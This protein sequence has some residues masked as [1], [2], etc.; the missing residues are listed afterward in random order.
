MPSRV[1]LALTVTGLF[2]VPVFLLLAQ[3]APAPAKSAPPAKVVTTVTVTPLDQKP[4]YSKEGVVFQQV[5]NNWTYNADGTGTRILEVVARVQSDAAVQSFGVL[6]FNYAAGDEQVTIDYLR[7]R[8]PDGTVVDTPPTDAE[9][10][11]TEVTREAPFYSDLKQLQIPVKSLS[12]G[13]QL[14]YR[15]RF[16]LIHPLAAGQ[17]WGSESW[18][19]SNVVLNETVELSI[20]DGKYVLVLS[21]KFPPKITDQNGRRIYAWQSSQLQPTGGDT[22]N[23]TATPDPD[24]LPDLSWTSWRNWQEIGDWYA[25]LAKD[26]VAVTPEIQS[27]VQELIQGK[28]SDDAKIEAIYDYVSLQVR[29]IGVAFGIGRYQPHAAETV[30]EN[31]YG[32]CK[33]KDTLLQTM[34]KAA[35]YDAWPALIGSSRKLHPELPSPE[36]FDHV[37]TVVQRGDSVIWLDSTPEVAPYRLL[38]FALRDK[39]ALVIPT[40]GEPKLMRTPA[41]GPFPF[42]TE[43]SAIASL[44]S[45]GTLTGHISFTVR[46]DTEVLFRA[47]YRATPRAQW[48]QLAQNM[49]QAMGFAGT[50][51][52][53]DVSRPDRTDDPFS[54][55]WKY[56]RKEYADWSD[57]RILPLMTGL[58]LPAPGDS[59]SVIELQA[60]QI[61]SFHSEITLP[62]QY[63]AVLPKSVHY[64]SAFATYDSTYKLVGGK[65]ISDRKFQVLEEQVPL[66]QWDKYKQ[67]SD[68]VNNDVNQFVQL[69]AAG[70]PMPDTSPSNPD[71]V[72]LIQAAWA[73][74][75]NHNPS[76]ARNDLQSAEQLNPRERGLWA[77]FGVL[78]A[79]DNRMD[80]AVADLQK[81]IQYHPDSAR[82][83]EYLASLQVRMQK[84][85]DAIATLRGLLK[86]F[87]NDTDAELRLGTLL[88]LQKKYDDAAALLEAA[89]KASPANKALAIQAGHA[90]ILAGKRDAG[91]TMLENVL[92]GADNPETLNDAAYELADA[93]LN[94]PF[95]ESS[96]RKALDLLGKETSTITL[97]NLSQDDLQHVQLLTATW[98]TMG[99]IYFREGKLDLAESYVHAAWITAQHSEIGDHLGQIYEKEGRFQDAANIYALAVAADT[100]SPDPEGGDA[101]LARQKALA[102]KGYR[103]K[104]S[105]PGAE[106]GN[107]RSIF[108]PQLTKTFSSADF[109]VLLSPGKVEDVRFISGDARLQAAAGTLRKADFSTQFPK[110]SQD[111]IVRRGILA[112]SGVDKRCQ[113][114]LLLPQ[115]VSLN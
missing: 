11:P 12:P 31:Q 23:K 26:R 45:D 51:S 70:S 17:F 64:E 48:Q 4:D 52:D 69:I 103:A 105:D 39:Q 66:D 98:D 83:Y 42:T 58:D 108:L 112:C 47:A 100:L 71:A 37:I 7:V 2:Q 114:T 32:D 107:Q 90:D 111:R 78:D 109:F 19:T 94:L 67:F 95:T 101:L 84:N 30:F 106:L 72:Q 91:G 44:D 6:N 92:N 55:S 33:D 76:A 36:Q 5:D 86:V 97:G 15:V 14:E 21:P 88:I 96:C 115:S 68:N 75:N 20:P 110:D 73:E 1:V 29:Y 89:A 8:K 61:E 46:G 102:A 87:P 56:D 85:E 57:H 99:W 40:S 16:N 62:A 28:T 41:D 63:T 13:D 3:Q 38:T 113:F 104:Y 53:V 10:M 50:V 22:G 54:F 81:E 80:D 25:S 18:I 74:L 24:A 82:I 43:Y 79:A 49:S 35:G 59:A 9:D 27:K 93:G 34:L 60:R 77:E 65:F